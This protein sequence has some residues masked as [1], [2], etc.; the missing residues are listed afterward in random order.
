MQTRFETLRTLALS[1]ASSLNHAGADAED[2]AQEVCLQAWAQQGRFDVERGSE[3]TWVRMIARSRARD[4]HRSR[5]MGRRAEQV[6]AASFTPA[7]P[8]GPDEL[9]AAREAEVRLERALA[10]IPPEQRA[11]LE[12]SFVAGLSHGEIAARLSQPLGTVKTRM[13]LGIR[14]LA[15]A[16]VPGG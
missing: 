7:G 15:A 5:K 13:R 14:A 2:I 9:F 3:T 12:L 10:A 6:L 4:A 16:L 1:I 8:P 11:I